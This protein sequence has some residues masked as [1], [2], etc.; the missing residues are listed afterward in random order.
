MLPWSARS[1]QITNPVTA[2]FTSTSSICVTGL[3]V[4][5][6]FDYWSPLGQ[7]IILALIHIGGFG[8]MITAT[9][10]LVALRRRIGLRGRL[11]IRESMGVEQLGGAVRIVRSML[12]FTLI[13][14]IVGAAL[15]YLRFSTLY[16]TGQAIWKSAFQSISAFNNAGFDIFGGFRSLT[17][18]QRDPL[19]VLVTAGLVILGGLSYL[20]VSD[21]ASIRRFSHFS[22]DTKL[23]VTSTLALL[24]LGTMVI[25]AGEAGNPA[26]LGTLPWPE[27]IM[28][29]FF[30]AAT[31]RTAGFSTLNM[32]GFAIYSLFFTMLL[33]FIGGAS[34]STAGGIKVNTFGM[35]IATVVSSIRGK[36]EA[37]VFGRKFPISQIY[38][39][40]TLVIIA[41]AVISIVVFILTVVERKFTFLQ[42]LFETIS[43]F[44]TVG[45][46][47][48]I[49]PGLSVVG[50]IL[51][52]MMM[53]IGRIG[54]LSLILSL[55]QRQRP[56]EFSYPQETIRIG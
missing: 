17:D 4:V 21:M 33:M 37:G 47:T 43:A 13:V 28:N 2:L 5:D 8:F 19:I 53:F 26:T 44:G 34:G 55:T 50:K 31:P 30:H 38:R 20:V 52:T 48:G 46:T 40:L 42:L 39:A 35:L 24:V 51:I 9:L 12:F 49:T 36:E 3:T 54:P 11:L 6:T 29:A 22:L 25:L 18:F 7:G 23:V 32:G 10:V 1:G 27:K 56:T 45:L 14:E 16:G 15:F 41:V